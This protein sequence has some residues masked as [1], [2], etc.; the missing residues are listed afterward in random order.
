M[1]KG[2]FLYIGFIGERSS[3]KAYHSQ[4]SW[5]SSRSIQC[6]GHSSGAAQCSVLQPC[7]PGLEPERPRPQW[8]LEQEESY[9]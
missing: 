4:Q 5:M 3:G 6:R 9:D 2:I 8:T 7:C 1:L